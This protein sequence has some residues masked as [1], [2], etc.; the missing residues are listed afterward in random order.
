M[1]FINFIFKTDT[2]TLEQ[3][4]EALRVVNEKISSL[5]NELILSLE[6]SF[7]K[8]DSD[9]HRVSSWFVEVFGVDEETKKL[10]EKLQNEVYCF[11]EKVLYY[12]IPSSPL[13]LIRVLPNLYHL[14][15]SSSSIRN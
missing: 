12:E 7:G 5:K 10:D 2:A 14:K 8:F 15:S 9:I 13:S 1:V 11:T 3:F 4:R 6:S